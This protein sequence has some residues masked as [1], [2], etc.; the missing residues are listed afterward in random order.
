MDKIGK[1]SVDSVVACQIYELEIK[2]KESHFEE[3]SSE[4][5]GLIDREKID[6]SLRSLAEWGIINTER[7]ST[8]EGKDRKFYHISGETH[9]AIRGTYE[10]LGKDIL[11]SRGAQGKIRNLYR[12]VHK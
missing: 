9:E 12:R 8:D 3:I 1:L 10:R 7:K 2:G 6:T 11:H 4:L 5:E